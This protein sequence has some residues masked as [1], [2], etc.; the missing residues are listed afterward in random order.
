MCDFQAEESFTAQASQI[1]LYLRLTFVL[2]KVQSASKRETIALLVC[3]VY[4][5]SL[6]N[7][8]Q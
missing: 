2:T 3:L 6:Q 1:K 4:M 7:V 5:R 8:S